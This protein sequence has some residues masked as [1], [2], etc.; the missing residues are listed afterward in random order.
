M[1]EEQARGGGWV[2]PLGLLTSALVLAVGQPLVLVAVA[3]AMLTFLA[4]AGRIWVLFLA[5]SMFAVVFAGQPFGGLWSLERGWAI[6]LGGWF[7]ALSLVLPERPFLRRA[8]P[9]LVASVLCVG[10]ILI[11]LGGWSWVESLVAQ[12]IETGAEATLRMIETAVQGEL[13][14]GL[15]EALT[16]TVRVQGVL[17]PALLGLSSLAALGV[18]WWLH[19][20]MYPR[21]GPGLSDLRDFRFSD[22]LVWVLISGLVLVLATEWSVGWGRL[23]TNLVTFMGALYMLRGVAVLAVVLGGLSF[24]AG[25]LLALALVLAGPV[26]ALG[27]ILVGVGDSWLDLRARVARRRGGTA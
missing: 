7:V 1:A 6:V 2:S 24:G 10:A 20:R 14:A 21:A 16:A 3:F 15:P 27:T 12:R 19:V 9:A 23:G 18:A 4:P 11:A 5:V 22:A 26:V 25:L 8:L 13:P 17:F